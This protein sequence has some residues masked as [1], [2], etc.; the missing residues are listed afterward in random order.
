[1]GANV[2]AHVVSVLLMLL[3]ACVGQ[4]ACA[5]ACVCVCACKSVCQ[6]GCALS[7]PPLQQPQS[8]LSSLSI[9]ECVPLSV[10]SYP[11]LSLSFPGLLTLSRFAPLPLLARLSTARSM[12]E[13]KRRSDLHTEVEGG[14]KMCPLCACCSDALPCTVIHQ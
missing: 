9:C 10:Y 12:T 6:Y 13:K 2:R 3:S 4:S 7:C 14:L 5:C 8:S 11:S 1:M